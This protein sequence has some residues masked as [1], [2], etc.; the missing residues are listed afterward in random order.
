MSSHRSVLTESRFHS[1]T[2]D[3]APC[4]DEASLD[5]L[6]LQPRVALPDGLRGVSRDEPTAPDDRL[7]AAYRRVDSDASE[8][9]LLGLGLAVQSCSLE[10]RRQDVYSLAQ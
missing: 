2:P 9:F 10:V 3:Q 1:L 4:V 8:E 7:P 5:V 6:T